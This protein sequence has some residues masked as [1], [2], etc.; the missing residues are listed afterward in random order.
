MPSQPKWS[1]ATGSGGGRFASSEPAEV[2]TV[3]I[4]AIF[5]RF[6]G[7]V[8]GQKVDCCLYCDSNEEL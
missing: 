4:D 2:A 1:S 3:E 5:G 6:V 7:L 8:D